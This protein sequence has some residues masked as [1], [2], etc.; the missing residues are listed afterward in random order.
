M[1]ISVFERVLQIAREEERGLEEPCLELGVTVEELE[2]RLN[3]LEPR[4]VEAV[5]KWIGIE[6]YSFFEREEAEDPWRNRAKR[7][8]WR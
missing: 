2:Q 8:L 3:R 1:K 7:R 4:A 5:A 6:Y